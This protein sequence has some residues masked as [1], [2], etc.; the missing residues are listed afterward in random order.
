MTLV[1]DASVALTWCFDD[2]SAA[3]TE[4]I[5]R[6]VALETAVVPGIFHLELANILLLGERKRHITAEA[7]SA[8]LKRIDRM[9]I[10]DDEDTAAN[11]W[12]ATLELAQAEK[13]TSYD[14]AY[15]ELAL[16]L[17]AD[18]ATLD[19]DLAEAARR[20]GLVVLP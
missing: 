5:G 14:A 12:A 6:R 8:S 10:E 1:I 11:A 17:E 2:E 19:A 18:L 9:G 15:L 7:I 4:G 20:R 3:V 16:R 13:L